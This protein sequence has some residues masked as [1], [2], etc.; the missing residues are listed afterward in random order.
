M[1]FFDT[2][3]RNEENFVLICVFIRAE[4]LV[5]CNSP[6]CAWVLRAQ[7]IASDVSPKFL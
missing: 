3:F 1:G 6:F 2:L 4:I 5:V 7:R